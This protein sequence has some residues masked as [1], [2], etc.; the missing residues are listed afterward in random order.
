MSLYLQTYSTQ[1]YRQ[2]PT[3]LRLYTPSFFISNNNFGEGFKLLNLASFE[4]FSCL[5]HRDLL[6]NF[7]FAYKEVAY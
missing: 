1:S 3:K 6:L 4:A 2:I 5:F 7:N